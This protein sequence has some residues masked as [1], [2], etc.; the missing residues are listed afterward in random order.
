MAPDKALMPQQPGTPAC[1]VL[2][3]PKVPAF[4]TGQSD[5]PVRLVKLQEPELS[6]S[7]WDRMVAELSGNFLHGFAWSRF[8]AKK[9]ATP[10]YVVIQAAGRPIAAAWYLLS[11]K[12][13]GPL[14][15]ITHMHL[16]TLPCF[17]PR[18][19]SASAVFRELQAH[20][21]RE[22]CI[23]LSFG[24]SAQDHLPAG[25]PCRLNEKINFAID[26]RPGT[27][28]LLANLHEKHRS[29]VRKAARTGV[30][31]AVYD[32]GDALSLV[33]NLNTM[34]LHS[35]SRHLSA[36]KERDPR[37]ETPMTDV[38][39]ELVAA[40]HA[41]LFVAFFENVPVSCYAAATFNNE[42][43]L[44]YGASSGKGY[45]LNASF[46]AVWRMVE[47]FKERGHRAM[48]LGSVVRTA[49]NSTDPDHGLYR[50]KAGF[51]GEA[52][53]LCSGTLVLRPGLAAVLAG[54]GR[55]KAAAR[56]TALRLNRP[57]ERERA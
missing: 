37:E 5:L 57:A 25:I 15:L 34:F 14:N 22:C 35:L 23:T 46:A 41:V 6:A 43:H 27:A 10:H 21:K 17:D 7:G 32:S 44:L 4:A 33:D 56:N 55:M 52:T 40:G 29:R 50:F 9:R 31:V 53:V 42:A 49:E 54:F 28:T 19:I 13:A 11:G 8:I 3:Q 48:S 16:E 47:Y 45:E 26:L 18:Y 36:G 51:G 20:A 24:N 2:M 1:N 30:R 39:T 12:K 38:V